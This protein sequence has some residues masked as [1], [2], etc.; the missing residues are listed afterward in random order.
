LTADVVTA[1]K[2]AAA[3]TSEGLAAELNGLRD[4]AER[5]TAELA[6]IHRRMDDLQEQ[7]RIY[8]QR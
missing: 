8:R 3:A 2:P 6:A 1:G 5:I 4:R 7:I